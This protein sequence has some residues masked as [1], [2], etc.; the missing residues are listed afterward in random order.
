V[1]DTRSGSQF[2]AAACSLVFISSMAV[3]DVSYDGSTGVTGSLSGEMIIPS[4]S[5]LSEGS[6]LF[7]SFDEF[8]IDS[9]DE[10]LGLEESV[11]FINDL[12]RTYSNIIARVS[13]DGASF[14]NG[15]LSIDSSFTASP[16][17]FFINPN[18]L[19]FGKNATVNVPGAFHLSTADEIIFA[20]GH[21]LD[22]LNPGSTFSAA[23]PQAFG[24]LAGGQGDIVL[25]GAYLQLESRGVNAS[26]VSLSARNIS[27]VDGG[28]QVT[29]LA[30]HDTLSVF[31]LGGQAQ[32]VSISAV[33]IDPQDSH[34]FSGSITLTNGF[35]VNEAATGGSA[36]AGDV[37]VYAQDL[38]LENESIISSSS[39]GQGDAGT[40]SIQVDTLNLSDSTL[41]TEALINN[42]GVITLNISD[43]LS[44]HRGD[45]VSTIDGAGNAGSVVI[46]VGG[47]IELVEAEISSATEEASSGSAGSV[48]IVGTH[49]TIS[50][51]SEITSSS[52]GSGSAGRVIIEGG[53]LSVENSVIAA[54]SELPESGSAGE[55]SLNMH[56]SIKLSKGAQVSSSTAGLGDAGSATLSAANI[57]IDG[58]DT[59]VSSSATGGF[60]SNSGNV[61]LRGRNYF[62]SGGA[63]VTTESD[64]GAGG[65]ISLQFTDLIRIEDSR[66]T[67][68]VFGGDSGGGDIDIDPIAIV[69]SEA[70]IQANATQGDGGN[71]SIVGDY[72]VFEMDRATLIEASSETGVDGLIDTDAADGNASS[73]VAVLKADFIS[74]SDILN[75][76]CAAQRSGSVNSL[77]VDRGRQSF[78]S[79]KTLLPVSYCVNQTAGLDLSVAATLQAQ[80]RHAELLK[81]LQPLVGEID[82]LDESEMSLYDIALSTGLLGLSH[83]NL[84]NTLEAEQLLDISMTLAE[85]QGFS[86]IYARSLLNRTNLSLASSRLLAGVKQREYQLMVQDAL[87]SYRQVAVTARK[88]NDEAL[89]AKADLYAARTLLSV[90]E[91]WTENNQLEV[92]LGQAQS[93]LLNLDDD[94][95][96]LTL[97]LVAFE[98][99]LDR[100]LASSSAT[101][102]D[103]AAW[104]LKLHADLLHGIDLSSELKQTRMGSYLWSQ[105]G[106]L[107]ERFSHLDEAIES[108]RRAIIQAEIAEARDLSF[109]WHA[110]LAR[111]FLA[112]GQVELSLQA[113]EKSRTIIDT[114]K[115]SL[116]KYDPVS[117]RSL[118]REALAPIYMEYAELLLSGR[119]QDDTHSL[120]TVR[121]LMESLKV[122]EVEQYFKDDCVSD[123]VGNQVSLESANREALILYPIILADRLELIVSTSEG[124]RR[125]TSSVSADQLQS[126]V[127]DYRD[128]LLS[129]EDQR[130]LGSAQ[131]LYDWLIRPLDSL[132]DKPMI[133]TLVFIPD[134]VLRTIPVSAFHDGER[135][136]LEKISLATTPGLNLMDARA[137]EKGEAKTLLLG[138]SEDKK[139]PLP[140]VLIELDRIG[141]VLPSDV[142]VNRDFTPA[143]LSSRL[144]SEA[145]SI[146]HI[147]T[148][149]QFSS[150]IEDSYLL[151]YDGEKIDIGELERQIGK[152][153]RTGKPIEL[154]A[155]SACETAVGNDKAA[156]GLAGVAIKAGA[157]SVFASLWKI[158]DQSTAVL[159]EEFYRK[160]QGYKLS[161]AE[162]LRAA[163]LRLLHQAVDEE[164]FSH[165]YYWAPFILLGNWQWSEGE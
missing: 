6:N 49:I 68:S 159:V 165:P 75:K 137:V 11:T 151:A 24:F 25:D 149:A 112:K 107:Y 69:L 33:N 105:T 58:A 3:A 158:R 20:D 42:A 54:A 116:P 138:L 104:A 152:T 4:S 12:S 19:T 47:D 122:A 90:S 67:T 61:Y 56:E 38:S 153:Q 9:G 2:G 114:I 125:F 53:T 163:Q 108:T 17:F 117:G 115:D 70:F 31:A 142:L 39:F 7:H 97:M 16:N 121:S 148:H 40:L 8:N 106:R 80:G 132:L 81:F 130:Y 141:R 51:E 133:E 127:K 93:S 154:L 88:M 126:V 157:R 135:F 156:L 129:P 27:I 28:L 85:D 21:R 36:N 87:A 13:G 128:A 1:K 82:S 65:D 66:V 95:E 60:G 35:L 145:Y 34:S 23:S 64:S 161:K 83:F 62:Q 143:Q 59:F 46:R 52:E 18:G 101:S 76:A 26:P 74:A 146:V 120:E 164:D 109:L 29:S 73:T 78:N 48:S 147:A 91:H 131:K 77:Y 110:Q 89:A 37:S 111:L 79:P 32:T 139:D 15:P 102:A 150:N 160:I 43:S 86:N 113:Y 55:V 10:V 30:D 96:K 99:R 45:I 57:T 72:I 103:T 100:L 71:I 14:I 162:A 123:L 144:E 94:S 41:A 134:G 44:V 50:Q 84:G 5:G 63:Q 140:N 155:L 22:T 98:L 118:F 92:L 136:L 124:L 119:V